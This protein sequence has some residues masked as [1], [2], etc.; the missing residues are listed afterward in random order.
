[1]HAAKPKI[2][3]EPNDVEL[4]LGGTAVFTCRVSGDPTPEITWML[5]SNEI[6]IDYSRVNILPDGSL[7]VDKAS[8]SDI[9]QYEC[10]AKNDMGEVKSKSAKMIVHEHSEEQPEPQRPQIIQP[11]RDVQVT[12]T[13]SII[14]HC[15]SDGEL[16]TINATRKFT[17][18]FIIS[19]LF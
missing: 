6:H 15:T 5:N 7:R 9:G 8:E 18:F 14:L 1:M 10:M 16:C 3:E 11:P 4:T 12:S 13:E 2:V 17:L 19:F